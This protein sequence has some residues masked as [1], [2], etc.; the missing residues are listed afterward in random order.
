MTKL[1]NVIGTYVIGAALTAAF[2]MLEPAHAWGSLIVRGGS[3]A[4]TLRS[5]TALTT[6]AAGPRLVRTL[7][8]PPARAASLRLVGPVANP[9]LIPRTARELPAGMG[10]RGQLITGRPSS[11][12]LSSLFNNHR[13]SKPLPKSKARVRTDGSVWRRD[14]SDR[15]RG[16]KRA[17]KAEQKL[18]KETGRGSRNWTEVQK[19]ELLAKGKVDGFAGHHINSVSRRPD[20]ARAPSNIKFVPKPVHKRFHRR[21]G[22][23]VSGRLVDREFRG[24]YLAQQIMTRGVQ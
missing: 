6:Y 20:L 16:I 14:K 15:A 22:N 2:G 8:P 18:V 23:D 19:Q 24:D 4:P 13:L 5:T 17:W 7:P 1:K 10:V 21:Y 3:V 11:G 9:R 12:Q